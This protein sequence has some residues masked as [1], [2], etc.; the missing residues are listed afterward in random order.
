[1][2]E[3]IIFVY[4]LSYIFHIFPVKDP[5]RELMKFGTVKSICFLGWFSS[6]SKEEPVENKSE[7]R[8]RRA[9]NSVPFL[10]ATSSIEEKR[11]SKNRSTKGCPPRRKQNSISRPGGSW[12]RGL[13]CAFSTT[14]TT[15]RTTTGA[16]TATI[17]ETT[18]RVPV[19]LEVAVCVGDCSHCSISISRIVRVVAP[20]RTTSQS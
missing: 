12:R 10:S 8:A 7:N 16:T 11:G 14:E 13:A 2:I 15:V 9:S 1:M 3:I 19:L 20:V 18:A 5:Y 6:T 4:E 17:A